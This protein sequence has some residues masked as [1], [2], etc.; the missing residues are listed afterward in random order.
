MGV[1]RIQA[2]LSL[3]REPVL[4]STDDLS[5]PPSSAEHAETFPLVSVRDD[6]FRHLL[7]GSDSALLSSG[8]K[9]ECR[10]LL[11]HNGRSRSWHN[12]DL[13]WWTTLFPFLPWILCNTL[14]ILKTMT[15]GPIYGFCSF[16]DWPILKEMSL[17][18]IPHHPPHS[19][20]CLI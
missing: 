9:T 15:K 7:D 16:L 14:F 8:W 1:R 17:P 5:S 11:S 13:S 6:S 4:G 19:F 2:G 12:S 3:P 18:C 10:S 20:L